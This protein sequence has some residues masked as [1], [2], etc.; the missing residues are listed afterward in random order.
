MNFF[1]LITGIFFNIFS[2]IVLLYVSM[3]TMIGPWIA[4]VIVLLCSI[5]FSLRFKL[6]LTLSNNYE[7]VKE[8]VLIQA[9]GS[10]GGIIGVGMG[11][12]LPTL[13]FLSP[14]V[15]NN[16]L[17]NPAHF[18]VFIAIVCF[19]AGGLGIFLAR[20]FIDKF[21]DNKELNFPVSQII[22]QTIVS[23]DQKN[24]IKKMSLGF[25]SSWGVGFLRD[26]FFKFKSFLPHEFVFLPNF[27]ANNFVISLT[28]M[29]WAIGFIAG[30]KIILPLLTGIFLK[31]F[32]LL[33]INSNNDLFFLP[34]LSFENFNAIFCSGLILSEIFLSL[35]IFLKY[36][37]KNIKNLNFYEKSF[38]IKIFN[39][40]NAFKKSDIILILL[41]SS[42]FFSFFS[43]LN[44]SVISQ[45]FLTIFVI[46]A[47][48]QI[49]YLGCKV[50]LVSFGR[51]ATFIMIPMLLIFNLDFMQITMVCV[52]FNVCSA[53]SSDLLFDY[54]I[55]QLCNIDFK[56]I[57]KYQWIGLI[58]TS[59]SIGFF[60]WLFF[61][62]FQIGSP[63]LF[64]QRGKARAILVQ[65]LGFD[66]RVIL[67][68]LFSGIIL[69]KLKINP[70]MV[71]SGI[72]M[73]NSLSIGLIIGAFFARFSKKFKNFDAFWSGVFTGESLWLLLSILLKKLF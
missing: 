48:Y 21:I 47:T 15:F 12:S 34:S 30:A 70:T 67:M 37:L 71:L 28:P 51:F 10:V 38:F 16:L 32:V 20:S 2:I 33:P 14:E 69:K 4:P 62:N 40:K 61:T 46:F 27:F 35:I 41:L 52:F 31:Y 50:G 65:S 58:I 72:L 8:T 56:E 66:F 3:A 11:F 49:S 29:F 13:Y 25:F 26:G 5:L 24:K 42:L 59:I 53:V 45:I 39:I 18:C 64:A 9:I 55:G 19:C 6:G 44:F 17:K 54:K 22:Y 1:I 60:L 23:Q 68:G 63:A 57:Y 73:P 7:K 43:Y 36:F